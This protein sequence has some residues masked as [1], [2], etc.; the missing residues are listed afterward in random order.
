[1]VTAY[2]FTADA[3]KRGI[4]RIDSIHAWENSIVAHEIEGGAIMIVGPDTAGNLL[5][6]G[7]RWMSPD[8]V[9]IFHVM[10]ARNRWLR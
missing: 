4:P 3:D 10:E 9:R 2:T 5:E 8:T 7:G 6:V 1:M